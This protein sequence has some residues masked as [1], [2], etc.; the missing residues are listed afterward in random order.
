MTVSGHSVALRQYWH[1]HLWLYCFVAVLFVMGVVFG[2]LLVNALTLEQRDDLFR[3]LDSF[4]QSIRHGVALEEKQT[5][6]GLMSMHLKW[7]AL[8]WLFALS[9]IGSP[10][11]LV[12]DF[13]KGVLIGF[14]FGY[15]AGQ[16]SWNGVLFAFA[17]VA[18]QN[19]LVV[20]AILVLS[21]SGISFSSQLIKSRF[22][23]RK[24]NVRK[25]FAAFTLLS[26]VMALLLV[27]VSAFE[28]YVSP[29]LMELAAQL[30]FGSVPAV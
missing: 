13:L 9:V 3:Y 21:V 2:A 15:L 14:T 8:L 22:L 1:D 17:S 10:L 30:I 27:G 20:P 4:I 7:V 18:P 25:S 11:I 5:F 19:L 26:C 23:G 6:A 29:Q 24:T 12:L 16:M 28:A